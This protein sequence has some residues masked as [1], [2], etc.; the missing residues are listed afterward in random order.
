MKVTKDQAV[1]TAD[2][3]GKGTAH[4][5]IRKADDE[6]EA[7]SLAGLQKRGIALTDPS[8]VYRTVDTAPLT[9]NRTPAR[10]VAAAPRK[11]PKLPGPADTP[12]EDLVYAPILSNLQQFV[13]EDLGT[14][15]SEAIGALTVIYSAMEKKNQGDGKAKLTQ[16][17]EIYRK[18][19]ESKTEGATE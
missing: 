12:I 10:V 4:C 16:Y 9:T 13:T 17:I 5:V 14:T 3:L 2:F 19:L 6:Y 8:V 11:S 18:S 15:V 7:I 1:K